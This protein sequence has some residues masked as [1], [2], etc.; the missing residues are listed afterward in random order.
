MKDVWTPDYERPIRS[1]YVDPVDL[2]WFST[3]RRLGL[4]IRRNGAIFSATDGTGLMELGPRATLDPDDC[5]A[6]DCA[7]GLELRAIKRSDLLCDGHD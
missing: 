3:A 6:H 2:V 1:R 4:T 5:A 7:D